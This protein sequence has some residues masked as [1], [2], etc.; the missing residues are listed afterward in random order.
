MR[1]GDKLQIQT[2]EATQKGSQVAERTFTI[3]QPTTPMTFSPTAGS[4]SVS[5]T[6]TTNNA[7]LTPSTAGTKHYFLYTDNGVCTVNES[8]GAVTLLKDGN[9]VTY[10]RVDASGN[11]AAAV[12]SP[13]TGSTSS[14]S[15]PRSAR[16]RTGAAATGSAAPR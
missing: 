9:C 16:C 13:V 3:G 10:G 7:N 15:R 6:V 2:L 1:E 4:Y 5:G 8:T 12:G 11:Y 14:R